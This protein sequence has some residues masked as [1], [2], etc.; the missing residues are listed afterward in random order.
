MSKTRKRSAKALNIF[1]ALAML[2]SM[3]AVL[4]PAAVAQSPCTDGIDP[5]NFECNPTEEMCDQYGGV[6]CCYLE[7]FVNTYVKDPETGDFAPQTV[8][9]DCDEFYVNAVV[10]N[11]G[12]VTA[13]ANVTAEI[14]IWDEGPAEYRPLPWNGHVNWATGCPEQTC[15]VWEDD[16]ESEL[17]TLSDNPGDIADFWWLVHCDGPSGP[18]R[19]RVNATAQ[20]PDSCGAT[21]CPGAPQECCYGEGFVDI[22]QT[23]P[24][25]EKCVQIRIIEAPG[26]THQGGDTVMWGGVPLHWDEDVPDPY[27]NLP[28]ENRPESPHEPAVVPCTN[29]GIKAM[30]INTCDRTLTDVNA[31]I[32]LCDSETAEPDGLVNCPRCDGTTGPATIVGGD[33]CSWAVGDIEPNDWVEV[34]WT[35]HCEDPGDVWVWVRSSENPPAPFEDHPISTYW[36]DPWPVHQLGLEELEINVLC[37]EDG[38]EVC[39]GEDGGTPCTCWDCICDDPSTPGIQEM[40]AATFTNLSDETLVNIFV[41][42]S[43]NDTSLISIGNTMQYIA[44]LPPGMSNA[45]T[46]Y[47]P[48]ECT[49][50][51]P[52]DITFEAT[53]KT[54]STGHDV[55]AQD[56]VIQVLQKGTK[57]RIESIP[58]TVNKCQQFDVIG[59]FTNCN[60][61][62]V[63]FSNADVRIYWR[64]ADAPAP[65]GNVTPKFPNWPYTGQTDKPQYIR[66]GTDVTWQDFDGTGGFGTLSTVIDYVPVGRDGLDWFRNTQ[67]IH[68]CHCCETW[69][70]WPFKCLEYGDVEFYVTINTLQGGKTYFDESAIRI[71]H[72]VYKAHLVSGMSSWLQDGCCIE[73][74]IGRMLHREAFSPCQNMHIVFPVVNIG[75]ATA[76]DVEIDFKVYRDTGIVGYGET[77]DL[78]GIDDPI[79]GDAI[80]GDFNP[81]TGLGTASLGDIP[82]GTMKKLILQ[83]HCAGEGQVQFFITDL[84]GIDENTGT[85]VPEDNVDVPPCPLRVKQIP[86]EVEIVNPIT[87]Q[88]INVCQEF[89]VKAAITNYSNTML[90]D[91]RA[92]LY[93]ESPLGNPYGGAELVEDATQGEGCSIPTDNPPRKPS[94][95]PFDDEQALT[96][97]LGNCSQYSLIWYP[98]KVDPDCVA[99]VPPGSTQEVTWTLHCCNEGEVYIWVYATAGEPYLTTVSDDD[100][101]VV[102]LYEGEDPE[103]WPEEWGPQPVNVHQLSKPDICVTI[104]SPSDGETAIFTSEEFSVTALVNNTGTAP[105]ENVE[106]S[107]STPTDQAVVVLLPGEENPVE[108]GTLE[109]EE[110]R[111]ITWDL[112]ALY[113]GDIQCYGRDVEIRV[114]ATTTSDQGTNECDDG[115]STWVGII[116][117]AHLV[118]DITSIEVDGEPDTSFPVCQEFEVNYTV[119]NTGQADAWEVTATLDAFP[120]GSVRIAEA[121]GG[122]TQYIG[123]LAG[124]GYGSLCDFVGE[125]YEGQFVLHCKE[126]CESTLKITPAG[127]DECGVYAC[128]CQ[129]GGPSCFKI[130]CCTNFCF[131]PG[132]EIDSEFIEPVE[133]T[134]KQLESEGAPITG[135]TS[136]VIDLVAGWNLISLPLIPDN[137]AIASVCSGANVNTVYWYNSDPADADPDH[138][139]EWSPGPGG[140]LTEMNDGKA[141]WVLANSNTAINLSGSELPIPTVGV[142]D[143]PPTYDVYVGWNMVGFKSMRPVLAGTYLSSLPMWTRMYGFNAAAVQFYTVGSADTMQ[144]E[145]GYWLAVPVDGTIYP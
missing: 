99:S 65:V 8:F 49:G 126:A 58:D 1:I 81:Q 33:P 90:N 7:V 95:D 54:E 46:V 135:E 106:V 144:P 5:N 3:L 134:V 63:D 109:A 79:S 38:V 69:V 102:V 112:H 29:F 101:P 116:A 136:A 133:E 127:N 110:Q 67:K 121:Q 92:T 22:I 118:A 108:L 128:E 139:Y 68:I 122:Y 71:V 91:V 20:D 12:N 6:D 61:D 40:M 16:P 75:N 78:Q 51:G 94:G 60:E 14:S 107:I 55:T 124:W 37:P 74:G 115:D 4:A 47:W 59:A 76:E 88:D 104:L 50:T 57:A 53:G 114:N 32:Y 9:E 98:D 140:P 42:A 84:R 26:L 2:V 80:T 130:G 132:R 19:I 21:P 83:V 41:K 120:S 145:A 56:V 13:L 113:S 73:E 66:C 100:A 70:R 44:S 119:T 15:K 27:I 48:A 125:T 97:W 87:C 36:N 35:I 34:A 72:Q 93:W 45:V 89:A 18:E 141:Y 28:L 129:A 137:P 86:F 142:P 62:G 25:T 123:N 143:V 103:P 131:H 52:V 23:P 96:K 31:T 43:A 10:V 85:W 77:W 17:E 111:I 138:W 39:T 64:P 30:I 117:A 105:A 24:T 82:G 11:T